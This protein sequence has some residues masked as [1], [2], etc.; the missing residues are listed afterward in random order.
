ML[1]TQT[2]HDTGNLIPVG[3]PAIN[4]VADE[5]DSIFGITFTYN[6]GISF[7]ISCEGH[8]IY[9]DLAQY[10]S[11]ESGVTAG[12]ARMQV[13]PSWETHPTGRPTK[14]PTC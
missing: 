10:P 9:L 12:R 3:G 4:P 14:M 5:F 6:A 2:E 8:S 11:E 13:R 7:E 1:L